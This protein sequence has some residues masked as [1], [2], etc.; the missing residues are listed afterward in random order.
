MVG[1]AVLREVVSA[2]AFTAIA[3]SHHFAPHS[4]NLVLL[5]FHL[6]FKQTRTQ[7]FHGFR[8]VFQLAFFVL[9][10]DDEAR[11]NVCDADG[12]IGRIH[13]LPARSA[14]A[15][16]VDPQI[17]VSDFNIDFLNRQ[18]TTNYAI[19]GNVNYKL[20]DDLTT[21]ILKAVLASLLGLNLRKRIPGLKTA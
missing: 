20:T 7:N 21:A 5:A 13:A 19:F 8:L 10:A 3:A 6:R 15:E 9:T 11:G 18:T 2:D 4:G 1:Q 16:H 12:G 17:L 14:A